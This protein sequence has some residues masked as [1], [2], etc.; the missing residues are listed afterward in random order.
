MERAGD[1]T[2]GS[3]TLPAGAASPIRRWV[4]PPDVLLGSAIVALSLSP[5]VLP[6]F[7]FGVPNPAA[8]VLGFIAVALRRHPALSATAALL[9]AVMQPFPGDGLTPLAAMYVV[10]V[11]SLSLHGGPLLR[12]ASA[13]AAVLG[14][15]YA[16]YTF[17]LAGG[18]IVAGIAPHAPLHWTA[19]AAPTA[20][21]FGAWSVGMSVHLARDNRWEVALRTQAQ[22]RSALASEAAR[23]DRARAAM[24]RD[25]HDVVGHSLAVIIAQ[26]DS[27][28]FTDD[29]AELHRIAGNIA[30]AARSSLGEV[31]DVLT[32]TDV[33]TT[34]EDAIGFAEPLELLR[35][36]GLTVDHVV[37]GERGRLG[38]PERTAARRVLQEMVTNVLRHGDADEPVTVSETWWPDAV[39]VE[40]QNHVAAHV[41][42][43]SGRGLGNMEHRAREVDGAFATTTDD[44]QF[45]AR[46]RLPVEHHDPL[47]EV[48]L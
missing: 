13:V 34:S 48:T 8:L 3:I 46:V 22:R 16:A 10:V 5:F 38:Q 7:L 32:G 31:R 41:T 1:R 28:G 4:S 6:R 19:V 9:T 44:G 18:R 47:D 20:V 40:V 24:A 30:A 15:A 25:V 45:T 43:G 12:V 42:P 33:E 29:P 35:E 17:S 26:A 37:R 2:K 27:A 11:Y 14:G 36:T 21:L 23:A 39:V